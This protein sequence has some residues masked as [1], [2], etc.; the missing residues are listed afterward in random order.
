MAQLMQPARSGQ[1]R[2]DPESRRRMRIASDAMT[3]MPNH[4]AAVSLVNQGAR[5]ASFVAQTF[6]LNEREDRIDHHLTAQRERGAYYPGRLPAP[7]R[8]VD[9]AERAPAA[10]STGQPQAPSAEASAV[11]VQHQRDA[12]LTGEV[13]GHDDAHA[14][15]V[16]PPSEPVA[17][18]VPTAVPDW[19][20]DEGHT[21]D[22][23][24]DRDA[25]KPVGEAS[26]QTLPAS[27]LE[28]LEFEEPTGLKW[29]RSP[30]DPP[31]QAPAPRPDQLEILAALFD[32]R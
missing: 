18:A 30:A 14:D 16:A 15:D 13:A 6:P 23:T 32:L 11:P 8:T 24:G 12:S 1:I 22:V 19:A 31:D 10:V 27:Y 17:T 20:P 26:R 9:D 5:V 3:H 7:D 29:D 25:V 4:H 28:L 21:L 2:D